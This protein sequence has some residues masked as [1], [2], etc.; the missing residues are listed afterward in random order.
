VETINK[1]T[2][3]DLEEICKSYM[4]GK[5]VDWNKVYK[6]NQYKKVRLPTYEFEKRRCWLNME[7]E[8][9][10]TIQELTGKINYLA[11]TIPD[12]DV[13]F[14]DYLGILNDYS[15]ICLLNNFH[16]NNI[17]VIEN[18]QYVV[19]DLIK[20]FNVTDE[21]HRLFYALLDI[22]ADQEFLL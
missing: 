22:M 3:N 2:R 7:N 20:L 4:E 13:A 14:S 6:K 17:K 10:S 15:G 8:G 12:E 19:K 21:Y 1:N 11:K 9:L 16:D 5:D 18:E